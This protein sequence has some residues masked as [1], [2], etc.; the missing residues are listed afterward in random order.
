[1][2]RQAGLSLLVASREAFSHLLGVAEP[3][4]TAASCS[5]M[6]I[7]LVL[8]T[9]IRGCCGSGRR[10]GRG[11]GLG[12]GFAVAE[13]QQVLGDVGRLHGLVQQ[14]DLRLLQPLVVQACR[15][16]DEC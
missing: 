10:A 11:C 8:K 12:Q 1:M 6:C 2:A 16:T 15:R 7:V 5:C 13:R 4:V 14:H 9:Y 3:N